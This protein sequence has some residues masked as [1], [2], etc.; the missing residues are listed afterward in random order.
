MEW[1][2][3]SM[4]WLLDVHL[5]EDFCRVGDK[6]VQQNLNIDR[7]IVLNNIKSYKQDTGD[8]RPVSKIML[9][10]LLDCDNLLTILQLN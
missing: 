9:D 10:C 1:S 7:K 3:E 4:H 8:Q 5:G 2:I 6:D